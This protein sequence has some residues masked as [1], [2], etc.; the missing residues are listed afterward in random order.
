MKRILVYTAIVDS[1]LDRMWPQLFDLLDDVERLSASRFRFE[2]HQRSYI[3]AHALKRLALSIAEPVPPKDW[4]FK[5]DPFG[6]PSVSFESDLCFNI[7]HCQTLVCCAVASK[8]ELG[9]QLFRSSHPE[10]QNALV[11]RALHPAP[12]SAGTYFALG[13]D[14][15]RIGEAP[16]FEVA[17]TVFS[18]A[19]RHWLES[20]PAA[21]RPRGFYRLWTLKEA[22]VKATG[23]GLSQA[24]TEF[25]FAF[26]PLRV[27]FAD[28]EFGDS[29]KWCFREM[30][31]D[32]AHALALAWYGSPDAIVEWRRAS[33]EALLDARGC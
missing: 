22:F 16:P 19:E 30:A 11:A 17:S 9:R 29:A 14:V 25:S 21:E 5:S 33:F 15:E 8:S 18:A 26:A 6:K 31:P 24:L 12:A 10:S 3:A 7:S 4:R 28:P 1:R 2:I 20:L 32:K 27:S 23:R 13:V